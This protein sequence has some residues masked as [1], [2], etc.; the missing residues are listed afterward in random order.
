M[1]RRVQ[2]YSELLKRQL[3]YAYQVWS[4]L[5]SFLMQYLRFKSSLIWVIPL[6][7]VVLNLDR[8]LWLNN[9]NVSD[10]FVRP[11]KVDSTDKNHTA[12]EREH[13]QQEVDMS[14]VPVE[15]ELRLRKEA[16][17]KRKFK[18]ITSSKRRKN[19]T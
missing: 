16:K 15:V 11:V 12:E 3:P 8:L 13:K 9:I 5:L 19:H 18:P 2:L 1:F 14:E 6:G 7:K 17:R 10:T 4:D